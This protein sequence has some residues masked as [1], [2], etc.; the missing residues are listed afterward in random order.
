LQATCS[1]GGHQIFA[2]GCKADGVN[3]NFVQKIL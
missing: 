3:L 2:I 1:A